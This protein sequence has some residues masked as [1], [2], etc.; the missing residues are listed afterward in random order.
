MGIA[1]LNCSYWAWLTLAVAVSF[2][3]RT[4]IAG[5]PR[6]ACVTAAEQAQQLRTAHQLQAARQQLLLCAKTTCPAVVRSDC[7]QWLSEV[8][9]AQPTIIIKVNDP[10]GGDVVAVSVSIDGVPLTDHLDGIA[11]PIDPGVHKLHFEASGKRPVDE[12]VVIREGEKQRTLL[13]KF[14]PVVAEKSASDSTKAQGSSNEP[15]Q[16]RSAVPYVFAGAGVLALG[17]FAYFGINGRSEA[18]D[19]AA[20]CGATKSCSQAQVD[21]VKKKLLLADISLGIGL[22][23]LG[24]AAWMFVT[25]EKAAPKDNTTV[26]VGAAPGGG[27]VQLRWRF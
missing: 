6:I 9:L 7:S 13:V 27:S 24:I 16:S 23:S 22:V 17:S 8:D 1:R 26:Q 14:Q 2:S 3:S 4:A 12:Q 15:V 19:L 18:S 10:S 21:P 20:G 5:D 11:R 25:Q